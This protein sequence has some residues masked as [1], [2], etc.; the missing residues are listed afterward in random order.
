MST[1]GGFVSW[2][3][4]PDHPKGDAG[5]LTYLYREGHHTPFEMCELL[6]EVQLPIFVMREFVRHRTLSFN[7][8]SAR[9]TQMPNLHY[10][11][12]LDR[13]V[14]QSKTNKQGSALE[15]LD[16]LLAGTA[17]A[18]ALVLGLAASFYPALMAA[19]LDPNEALRAL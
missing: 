4:Y 2:D 13:M 6:L 14:Q 7:E 12:P 8:L 5:L 18:L 10:V 15:P 19:R 16:P 17:L 1:S 11:P 3:P 9:Y